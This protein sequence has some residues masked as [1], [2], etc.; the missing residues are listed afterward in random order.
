M[1][2]LAKITGS[3]AAT[4]GQYLQGK[5]RAAGLGDYYLKDGER[6]ETPGRWAA[7]AELFGLDPSVP[8]TAAQLH[9]LMAVTRP[10]NAQ[11]LRHVGSTGEA[12]AAIDATFSAPKT[13]SAIWALAD[14]RLRTSIEQAHE[15]AVDRA[16]TYATA[17]VPMVRRRLDGQRVVHERAVGLVATSWRHT[18]ARAVGGQ[19]PDPQLHSHLLLHG[20]VRRDGELVAIDSRMWLVHQRELGA[21]YRTELASGLHELGFGVLRG[22]GRGGRYFEIEGVP[23]SLIDRW[24]SRHK[25]VQQAIAAHLEDE[26]RRLEA[27]ITAGGPQGAAAA[28]RLGLMRASGMLSPRQERML[29][30]ITRQAKVPVTVA[31]LDREWQRTAVEHRFS[32]GRV[33]ALRLQPQPPLKEVADERVLEALTQ[34]DATFKAREARAV[35]LERNAGMPVNEALKQLKALRASD[36]I[37]KL[38]DGSGTTLAHRAREHAV[39]ALGARL[40]ASR[41]QPLAEPLTEREIERL[42]RTLAA[43]G[44]LSG[45]QREA[46]KS[47]CGTRQLV[48]IEGQAGTGKSTTLAAIARAHQADGH[49][50]IVTSTAA[51]AAQRLADE[52]AEHEVDSSAYSTAGLHAAISAGRLQLTPESTVIHD[53]AA[54]A[55]T[56]EQLELLRAVERSGARLIEVGDGRQS[57]PVGAGGLWNKLQH[58]A[59]HE[60]SL[61]RLTVN[62]RA[63]DPADRDAQALFRKGHIS[64]ALH[65]YNH[66]GRVHFS[67]DQRGAEDRALEAAHK[68]RAHGLATLVLAQTSNEQLDELNARAQAIRRE[69]G[70]LDGPG[71]KIPGR[72]Y[73]VYMGD[74]VQIRRST[75]L[76]DGVLLRNGTRGTITAADPHTGRVRLKLSDHHEITLEHDQLEQAELRLAYVQ[77]PFPAQGQTVDTAHVIVAEHAT[78]E[79]SYVALTRARQQTT[80]YYSASNENQQVGEE[81]LAQLAERLSRSEPELPSIS[82]P[83]A[84]ENTIRAS[85]EADTTAAPTD[86][87]REPTRTA[88]RDHAVKTRG[89]A[90]QA[91]ATP[92]QPDRSRHWPRQHERDGAEAAYNVE[93]DASSNDYGWER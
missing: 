33:Q 3:Q 52:L 81:P 38:A 24:S 73:S 34:F 71:V 37:L 76:A 7:G 2:I 15:T 66:R 48:V 58:T 1:L 75:Q 55:S 49:R 6:V 25:Q 74:E 17:Q 13:V 62:Q 79:E 18:T 78:T 42:D 31:D 19:P 35:A 23:Q 88:D 90:E 21:A 39:L 27:V 82:I 87:E 9:A 5:T 41:L 16:L 83:L 20:A 46:I 72:P 22:T 70:E 89:I 11:P 77:H 80:I 36:R 60:G 86:V 32:P 61:T 64:Q 28:G 4:Y 57:Q 93:H 14:A 51:L 85:L 67:T 40:T 47:A 45:E 50:I 26:Q 30:A 54:L 29:G 92:L 53:E 91:T 8:V 12:V 68:D 69:H 43:D 84:H 10:D 44:G 56:G 63:Q 65:S 59:R